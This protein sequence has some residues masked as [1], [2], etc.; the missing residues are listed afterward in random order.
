MVE[1]DPNDDKNVIVEIQGGAGGEEAGLWAGDVYRMLTKYAERRGF[2]TEPLEVGDGKYTFA[3]KGDGA[4]S[5]FKF[6]GGTHRVQRVP[7]TESQGRIHTSTATVAVLPEAEDVDV[8]IDPNDLQIDVYRSSGPGGQSVNTTDSAVRITHKPTGIVVSMQDEKSQLQN[9]EKAM[10]VLRARLYEQAMAEQQAELAAD[11]R[12]QV[13][14]GDRAEKIRTYN[15]GERR[16]TD[17]RI[18]LTVHNL[19]AVLEGELDEFTAA[20]QADEKRRRLEAQAARV[21]VTRR[22]RASRSARRW[23]AR[24]SRSTAAGC[25]TPRLDA[26][27]LLGA[28]ARRR[29]RRA[30]DR[31]GHAGRG[32]RPC[33][34]SRTPF[35]AA[36]PSASRSPTSLGRKGFRHIDLAVDPRV[37]IPRP[38]TELLVEAALGLPRGA[39]VADVGH[40]QRRRG[41]GAQARAAGPGA[42]PR[43]TSATDALAVARANAARL[44]ARR[45]VRR[46]PTC[47][48]ASTAPVDAV[49]SNPPYVAEPTRASLAPEVTR[50]EPA[51]ALFAGPRRAR[52]D[53]AAGAAGRG[54]PPAA[55][56]A[57]EVGAGPGARRS[58]ELLR[59]AGFARDRGAA[60]PRRHRARRGRTPLMLTAERRARPSSAAWRSAA[61]RC[62]RPTRSTAWPASPTPARPSQRLYAL[63]RRRPDK[64]AAVM[65]FALELALA[66]LPE[67]GPR[68]RAAARARCCPAALTLLLPNPARRFPLACGPGPGTLGLR[69]PALAAAARGAGGGALAGAAVERQRRRRPRR[70]RPRRR[71]AD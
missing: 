23:T 8:Q 39:R 54:A 21:V 18:K 32:A 10:R 1:R 57:L 69:V 44:G 40:G 51:D 13:G 71:A 15:Y 64:P 58:R 17:H 67:L 9:R 59:A 16:V 29:P 60:R 55:L 42:S 20:L 22:S 36:R 26:E 37:L 65:F 25:D 62:S 50:H 43:A 6:E 31:P 46:A 47:W 68:T 53:P 3:I 70:A 27:V 12:A 49:V 5:V 63:K 19:D 7:A 35:A 2:T 30:G 66:A 28:R 48:P 34:P 24:W 38:E 4:Y 56:L 14:T 41:A 61:S 33:A 11:R 52:R 45:V